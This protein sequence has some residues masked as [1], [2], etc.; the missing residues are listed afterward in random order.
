MSQNPKVG[1]E[2]VTPAVVAVVKEEVHRL[3]AQRLGRV[4]G[5]MHN[6]PKLD[7]SAATGALLGVAVDLKLRL[8]QK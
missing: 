1:D 2:T 7:Y 8:D 4:L 3:V 6:D 5:E